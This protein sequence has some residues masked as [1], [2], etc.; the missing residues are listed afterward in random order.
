MVVSEDSQN[1]Y[2]ATNI[3]EPLV[4]SLR[5]DGQYLLVGPKAM[6][7]ARCVFTNRPTSWLHIVQHALSTDQDTRH[8]V[9][10]SNR[11]WLK[12]SVCTPIRLRVSLT[13]LAG[14]M[15]ITGG[16]IGLVTSVNGTIYGAIVGMLIC[17]AG[18]AIAWFADAPALRVVGFEH[19]MFKVEGCCPE[20]LAQLSDEVSG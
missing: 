6:M 14:A 5:V 3:A 16:G 20:F 19:G 12:Y 13:T 2:A 9:L 4:R 7:P 15:M 17:L 10:I 8:F 11:C 18:M 1:P